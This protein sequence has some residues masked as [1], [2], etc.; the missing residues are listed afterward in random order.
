MGLFRQL[1]LPKAM[2]VPVVA[3]NALRRLAFNRVWG[4]RAWR[5]LVIRE[6][7]GVV[8][9]LGLRINE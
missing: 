6:E 5:V 9:A 8:G 4:L 2:P 7:W 3:P 1:R